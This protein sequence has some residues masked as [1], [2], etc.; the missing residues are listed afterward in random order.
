MNSG[1]VVHSLTRRAYSSSMACLVWA[2]DRV[3]A[4]MASAIARDSLMG[5]LLYKITPPRHAVGN[6]HVCGRLIR[7]AIF[8]VDD[9]RGPAVPGVGG[10]CAGYQHLQ[11]GLYDSR[12]WRC[13]R[14]DRAEILAAGEPRGE[15]HIQGGQ[16]GA[17][18]ANRKVHLVGVGIL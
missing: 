3:A 5:A 17:G 13:G 7:N 11:S 2:S 10:A 14:Q 15:V 12:H 4:S 9:G 8:S 1:A 18:V 16:P 6:R